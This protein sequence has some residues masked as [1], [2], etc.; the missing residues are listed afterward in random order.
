[1][2]K[3]IILFFVLII[4][5]VISYY[6]LF[7][8]NDRPMNIVY[9]VSDCLRADRLSSSGY[10]RELAPFLDKLAG[11]G[12]LVKNT[13]SHC[14]WTLPSMV[15]H[16]T[17]I[18][19][20]AAYKLAYALS[21]DL[22][23]ISEILS[24]EGYNT[25]MIS[26]NPLLTGRWNFIQGFDVYKYIDSHDGMDV[27]KAIEELC[28]GIKE[29][30]FLYVHYMDP[31]TPYDPPDEFLK[32]IGPS[33][34]AEAIRFDNLKDHNLSKNDLQAGIDSYDGEV[35]Y[36]DHLI[37]SACA[38]LDKDFADDILYIITAD[39]GDEF[40]DHGGTGHGVTLYNEVIKVPL[41]FHSPGTVPSGEVIQEPAQVIDIVPT[42]L[43]IA[44]IGYNKDDYEGCSIFSDDRGNFE[45]YAS[46]IKTTTPC[47]SI[48]TDEWKYIHSFESEDHEL[49][50]LKK[51]PLEKA[52]LIDK[53]PKIAEN[54]KIRL[55]EY[56][57]ESKDSYDYP[58]PAGPKKKGPDTERLEERIKA[59]GYIL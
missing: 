52:N 17:G 26:A 12:T 44:G 30:F 8:K 45:S 22:P 57:S 36:Q 56:N 9:I 7:I 51:D 27:N 28:S 53:F 14:S 2:K 49:Y 6:S 50:N 55:L 31:H 58:E 11:E 47:G 40:G 13:Y 46:V 15:S 18:N 39:H 24:E 48:I 43:D 21:P 16:L 1:M 41:I 33:L 34:E 35:M 20:I 19:Q 37:S 4:I 3:Y 23:F 25:Y 5:A 59:L 54:L 10:H 42:I 29:P 38:M 32:K